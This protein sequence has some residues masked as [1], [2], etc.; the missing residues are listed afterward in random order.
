[1]PDESPE[2]RARQSLL[3]IAIDARAHGMAVRRARFRFHPWGA[4]PTWANSVL[5]VPPYAAAAGDRVV[6]G[7][8]SAIVSALTTTLSDQG[9]MPVVP[10]IFRSSAAN[11]SAIAR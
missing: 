9:V 11:C 1:M 7:L 2:L 5:G 8:R 3:M 6:A 4:R 10:P